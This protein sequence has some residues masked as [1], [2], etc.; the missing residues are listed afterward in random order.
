MVERSQKS[1]NF[2]WFSYIAWFIYLTPNSQDFFRGFPHD[3]NVVIALERVQPVPCVF[4]VIIFL[5][6]KICKSDLFKKTSSI[7]LDFLCPPL[8]KT[9][10][11]PR[12]NKILADLITNQEHDVN[13][14]V[15]DISRFL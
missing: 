7:N 11:A 14:K 15:I 3:I 5:F 12:S 6:L 1:S 10:F 2:W 13:L 9:F 8:I 4:L